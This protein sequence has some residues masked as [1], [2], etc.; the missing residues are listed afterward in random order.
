MAPG[1]LRFSPATT[2]PGFAMPEEPSFWPCKM[3]RWASG[4]PG[5]YLVIPAFCN[6]LCSH[7]PPVPV[8]YTCVIQPWVNA[9]RRFGSRLRAR[10]SGHEPPGTRTNDE[11]AARQA[12]PPHPAGEGDHSADPRLRPTH[13]HRPPRIHLRLVEEAGHGRM[14][15]PEP[16]PTPY[17]RL[18]ASAWF[19]PK[20]RTA[21]GP[22][23]L[24]MASGGP[25]RP[26][27][28]LRGITAPQ[29]TILAVCGPPADRGGAK[30][31][32]AALSRASTPVAPLGPLRPCTVSLVT[33]QRRRR[34]DPVAPMVI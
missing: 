26:F 30:T 15:E 16:P 4:I 22:D 5:A 14:Y 29:R 27:C 23:T 34:N 10:A 7:P 3:R 33:C 31:C 28:A 17:S 13:N 18:Q 8:A 12:R 25:Q 20:T 1:T 11:G 21:D 19:P 24:R 9:C 6:R 2:G 32:P